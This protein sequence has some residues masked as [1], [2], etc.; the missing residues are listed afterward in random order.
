M[1]E[2]ELWV[3]ADERRRGGDPRDDA[4]WPEPDDH[5]RTVGQHL[6]RSDRDAEGHGDLD[7]S[8][9]VGP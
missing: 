7:R 3:A 4:R 2:R 1:R 8:L 9:Y 5:V 6:W